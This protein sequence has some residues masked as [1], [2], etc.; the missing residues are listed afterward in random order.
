MPSEEEYDLLAAPEF[1]LELSQSSLELLLS[2][3][4]MRIHLV[5]KLGQK[6]RNR[7][8]VADSVIESGHV[9]IVIIPNNQGVPLG[10]GGNL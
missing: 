7:F 5:I 10:P 1:L 4:V 9:S 6:R 8:C 3:V 2:E